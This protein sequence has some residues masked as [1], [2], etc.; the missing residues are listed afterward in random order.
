MTVRIFVSRD[1]GAVAVGAD[2]VALA[3]EQ[4]AAKRGVAI[5]VIRTGSRGL[6]W[7]E[8][9]IEIAASGAR[10]SCA[11]HCRA[12]PEIL[13]SADAI[14]YPGASRCRRNGT[15]SECSRRYRGSEESLKQ[16]DQT[17]VNLAAAIVLLLVPIQRGRSWK[18]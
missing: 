10:Q 17:A 4:V 7:L 15:R 2:E 5:E 6:Y 11:G 3:I 14:R 9:M 18:P 16:R 12:H 1:A 13:G 8:P